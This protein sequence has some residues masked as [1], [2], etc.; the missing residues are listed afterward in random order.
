M[1]YCDKVR[2]YIEENLI[3]FDDDIEIQNDD[4]IFEQGFVNSLFAMK[5]VKYIEDD[6]S[7]KL[8]NEDLNIS[9]FSTI[10]KIVQLV[11]LR[12]KE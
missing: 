2:S 10:N 5:L 4:N 3:I 8:K 11:Q 1:N 6:F 9:N 7:I 12:E